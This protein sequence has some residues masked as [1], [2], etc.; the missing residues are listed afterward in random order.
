MGSESLFPSLGALEHVLTVAGLLA[1]SKILLQ[2][3]W[4]VASGVRVHF[5]SRLWRKRLVED[6]GQWAGNE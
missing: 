3:L 5:W 2:L 4:S 6:Y 1:V